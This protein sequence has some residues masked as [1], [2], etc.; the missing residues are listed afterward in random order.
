MS[1]G[2][3]V[4]AVCKRLPEP[5]AAYRTGVAATPTLMLPFKSESLKVENELDPDEALLGES[6]RSEAPRIRL[7]GSGGV[8][9]E[10]WYHGLEYLLLCALGFEN[11]TVYTGNYGAGSGGSP[12][13][14]NASSPSAWYHLFELD[15]HLQIQPWSAGERAVA[16]GSDPA[17]TFW[18]ANDRKVRCVD[19]GLLKG[20]PSGQVHR[21]RS[22]MVNGF[23]LNAGTDGVSLDWD[24][25][26]CFKDYDVMNVASWAP[27]AG[28]SATFGG[29]RL[30][31]APQASSWT[32]T[33]SAVPVSGLSLKLENR[34]ALQYA[35]GADSIYNLEPIREN[36]RKVAGTFKVPRFDATGAQFNTWVE[37]QTKLQLIM[38]LVGP[39]L[40]AGH[41]LRMRFVLPQVVLLDA[42][43]PVSGPGIIEGDVTFEAYKPDTG[44]YAYSWITALRGG[45]T[46]V[47][48]SE[49]MVQLCNTQPACFSRDRQ[50]TGV[51]LP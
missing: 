20:L 14:D 48:N 44:V 10:A 35:S 5:L 9:T 3:T 16:S 30:Y 13:P 31:L 23:T 6:G 17:P 26:P 29:L 45:I 46:L 25:L 19:I 37:N 12:A 38:E 2:T 51:T 36:L 41:N 15:D 42:N 27:P 28:G 43:F 33:N 11:P 39:Q 4:K 8:S 40:V 22:C 34:L 50:A 47:K 18:T 24:V 21:Y 32:W 7:R 1:T 49:L